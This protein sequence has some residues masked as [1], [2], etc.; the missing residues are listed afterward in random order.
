MALEVTTNTL[1]DKQT[2]TKQPSPTTMATF[3]TKTILAHSEYVYQT[4]YRQVYYILF[5]DHIITKHT[6]IATT[7]LPQHHW[8]LYKST[9]LTHIGAS[10]PLG[11][12]RGEQSGRS[13][14]D[15]FNRR[16]R[17]SIW[18]HGSLQANNW[19]ASQSLR[20]MGWYVGTTKAGSQVG[21]E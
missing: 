6:S 17:F 4:V 2:R 11:F 20:Q 5:S 3:S 12:W 13:I 9:V 8:P 14:T 21:K 7:N 18:I 10:P 19:A 1:L 15:R 16:K